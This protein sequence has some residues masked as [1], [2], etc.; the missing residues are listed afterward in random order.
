M[1]RTMRVGVAFMLACA[2]VQATQGY[3]CVGGCHNAAEPQNT[4]LLLQTKLQMNG[5][6]RG[7]KPKCILHVGPPKTGT[8]S[9]QFMLNE[10]AAM[11]RQSD[12]WHQPQDLADRLTKE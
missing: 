6:D 3:Y 11:L 12:G 1:S 7:A 4:V 10:H 8:T 9:L 2:V 5:D